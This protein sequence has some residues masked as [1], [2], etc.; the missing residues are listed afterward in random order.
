MK[1]YTMNILEAMY[2]EKYPELAA[3]V[4]YERAKELH[5]QLNTLDI[6]WKRSNRLFYS[7]IDLYWM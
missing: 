2:R 5:S 3:N 6:R 4:I 1:Y 7:N